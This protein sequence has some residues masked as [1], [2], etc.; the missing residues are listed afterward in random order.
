MFERNIVDLVGLFVEN[1]Q[2][3]YPCLRDRGWEALLGPGAYPG[4]DPAPR[5]QPNKGREG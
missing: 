2:S 4:H 5:L 1:V 3:L